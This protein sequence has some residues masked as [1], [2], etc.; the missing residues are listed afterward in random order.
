M[1]KVRSLS[2]GEAHQAEVG[3]CSLACEALTFSFT[4]DVA[5][6]FSSGTVR[7]SWFTP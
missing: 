5:S 1:V 6:I 2:E 7:S 4:A 3:L